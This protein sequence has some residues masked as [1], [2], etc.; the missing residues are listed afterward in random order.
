[1]ELYK[2]LIYHST[3]DCYKRVVI[4]SGDVTPLLVIQSCFEYSNAPISPLIYSSEEKLLVKNGI[5]L[6]QD[7]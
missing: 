6:L 2:R 5:G 3:S 7:N 1:M 4:S